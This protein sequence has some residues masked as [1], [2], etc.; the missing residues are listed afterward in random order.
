VDRDR[1]ISAR[2][3]GYRCIEDITF[4][5]DPERTALVGA[6]GSGKTSLLD[7]IQLVSDLVRHNHGC[8]DGDLRG[9]IGAGS[10]PL[11][12]MC[13]Y[14]EPVD[15]AL[16]FRTQGVDYEYRVQL[17]PLK[18]HYAVSLETLIGGES[19]VLIERSLTGA[20]V[21]RFDG[22]RSELQPI[23][24]APMATVLHHA[25]DPVGYPDVAPAHSFLSGICT[26]R[27]TPVLMRAPTSPTD[28]PD[29]YGRDLSW[30]LHRMLTTAPDRLSY[31]LTFMSDFVGWT[32]L[33]TPVER[34]G[35]APTFQAGDAP[36]PI[37]LLMASDGTVVEAYLA[38]LAL[39]PPPNVS[40]FLIDEP[41]SQFF[42][43][44]MQR[45]AELLT[46]LSARK[47]V[48]VATHGR[49]LIDDFADI[50]RTWVITRAPAAGAVLR[51]LGDIEGVDEAV[52]AL[53]LGDA[54]MTE[55]RTL[56]E[57]KE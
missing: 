41:G 47:Q 50:T 7:A 3:R 35:V 55:A 36:S 27:L 39:D 22:K 20:R 12:E 8:L 30:R 16:A 49:E 37:S 28:E 57:A 54:A 24:N 9:S 29:R 11:R 40:V 17:Q 32:M 15:L 52:T 18:D 14:G 38:A 1:L 53:G 10:I 42:P 4:D 13:R 23:G 19:E 2:I 31:F 6:N 5:P 48:V 34:K 26:L 56:D 33:R 46:T 21:K 43:R 25:A 45:P 51:R 44:S